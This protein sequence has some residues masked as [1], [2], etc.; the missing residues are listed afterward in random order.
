M[1]N[2]SFADSHEV[3]RAYLTDDLATSWVPTSQI[4]IYPRDYELSEVGEG[5]VEASVSV[6]GMLDSDGRLSQPASDADRTQQFGVTQV[7]GQW[8]ISAFP[9]DFGL[10]LSDNAFN[11]QYL[12]A[13]INY[14]APEGDHFVPETRWFSRDEGLPTALAR[15]LLAPVP[16]YL[17]D[18]V[19]TGTSQE[20]S[21]VAGAVPVDPATGTAT[22]NLQGAGLTEEPAQVRALYAQFFSTLSQAA[23]VADVELQINGQPLPAPGVDGPVSTLSQV[24]IPDSDPATP[25]A[26][27]RIGQTLRAVD[28]RNFRLQDLPE[29]TLAEL[30]LDLP[31]IS[32]RWIDLAMDSS[33][34]QFAG[35]DADRS[36]LWRRVGSDQVEKRDIGEDLSPP[37]FDGYGSLWV[38]GRSANGP[39][40]WAI[41]AFGGIDSLARP[42]EAPWLEPQM[43]IQ[44]VSVAPDGQRALIVVQDPDGDG[45]SDTGATNVLLS[46]IVRDDRGRPS[47]L[48]PPRTIAPTVESVTDVS[49]ASQD[50]LALLGKQEA[51]DEARPYLLPIGS[52]LQPLQVESGAQSFVG[53]PTGEGY[54]LAIV[55]DDGRVHTP[56]GAGWF[57][58][59]NADDLIVPGS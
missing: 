32:T 28:P 3:A 53:M 42:V 19:Y 11:T 22:V 24:G 34:E 35:V 29:E 26:V 33:A 27:L 9:Q 13:S 7:G 39:R 30:D 37:S 51:D 36:V 48:N 59:R 5:E 43:R 17:A 56:E 58:Y 18:A 8:R 57:P 4:L 41:D 45:Q 49:W 20:T 6:Q 55:T 21:L 44:S 40:V 14:L 46:G 50:S 52:W 23:G 2:V 31:A 47:A 25:I 16:T 12:T 38:A 10:W 15:A 54:K 1:A